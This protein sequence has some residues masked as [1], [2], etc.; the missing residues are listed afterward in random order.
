[1]EPFFS[2]N[3]SYKQYQNYFG[4]HWLDNSKQTFVKLKEDNFSKLLLIKKK[5]DL[6]AALCEKCPASFMTLSHHL[7][8]F[9]HTGFLTVLEGAEQKSLSVLVFTIFFKTHPGI[10]MTHFLTS[11][12]FLLNSHLIRE[13]FYNCFTTNTTSYSWHS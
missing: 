6:N 10:F 4:D 2:C 13:I 5:K 9:S 3:I 12:S 1:M 11:L 7:H 8:N